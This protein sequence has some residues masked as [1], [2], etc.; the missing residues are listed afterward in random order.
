VT[1]GSIRSVFSYAGAVT[2]T[3]QVNLVPKT[4]GIIQSIPVDVGTRVRA[5]QVLATLD[6]GTLTDQL[7]Q[8]QAGLDQAQAKLQQILAQGRPEDVAAATAQLQQAQARLDSMTAQGR[9]EDINAAQQALA[10]AQAK[11]D[12]MTQGGRPEAIGQAQ[13]ALDAANAKLATV[14]R[15]PTDD[16][17]QA[18]RNSVNADNAAVAAA[19]AAVTNVGNTTSSD[20]QAAQA[21]VNASQA[22]VTQA[23]DA[24]TN[25]STTFPSDL[26]A[27]QNAYDA[28]VMQLNTTQ[29]AY[30]EAKNQAP[31]TAPGQLA[32]ATAKVSQAQATYDQAQSTLTAL[33]LGASSSSGTGAGSVCARDPQTKNVVNATACNAALTAANSSVTAAQQG[34]TNAQ[35]ALNALRQGPSAAQIQTQLQPLRQAY[36]SADA[37]ASAARSKLD[38]LSTGG[39]D[40]RENELQQSL[41]SAQQKLASDQSRLD[42]LVA[43]GIA[44]QQSTAQ[45]SLIAAQEKL[46]SDQARL[47]ELLSQPKQEDVDQAQAAV[48]QASQALALAI[49]PSTDEDI[50]AQQALVDQSRAQLEKAMTPFTAEDIR[51]QREVVAQ[52]QALLQAKIRP[53]TNDDIRVAQTAV[54]QQRALV[55]V[56]RSNL[57]QMVLTAPFDGVVGSKLLAVGGFAAPQTPILTL[58]G[59]GLEI[60][61]TVEEARIAAVAPGQLVRLSVPA[62]PDVQFTG[63]VATVA[64]VGDPRAHTFDVTIYPDYPDQRLMAGMYAQV[65]VTAAEKDAAVLIPREAVVQQADGAVVFV[66]DNK[67]AVMR[68]VQLGLSDDTNQEI[69]SGV[70]PGENVVVQGQNSLKDGQAIT[71]PGASPAASA[72]GGH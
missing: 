7:A 15:G 42:A 65:Q 16:L 67:K 24:L 34:L 53:F 28:A 43:S 4:S 32:D 41:S 38:Q 37:N 40:M 8:A 59:T 27:A 6:P 26:R 10:A 21:A 39:W 44:S 36:E 57:D 62:Y 5:G 22:A 19:Q 11:L 3:D 23:Q 50:R 33:T 61:I 48:V 72:A 35:N 29:R 69:L 12:N 2:A 71:L 54:D 68:K 20:I 52:Q 64:P 46:K 18:A 60:H 47:D 13:A 25:G 17:V 31:V 66:D 55:A 58:S 56:A 9:P 14:L 70:D 63:H 51:Q 49:R 30:E 1:T 45:S